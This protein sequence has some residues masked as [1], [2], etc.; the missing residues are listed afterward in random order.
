MRFKVGQ[1]VVCIDHDPWLD[2]LDQPA[3][4]PMY[5]EIVTVTGYDK[6]A[7]ITSITVME[8]KYDSKTGEEV[9][10]E[11]MYF[12]PLMDISELEYILH[13]QPETV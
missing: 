7:D 6:D 10:Y 4:G 2:D 8:Y 3:S 9:C 13:S 5:N 11:E 12:A 1:K